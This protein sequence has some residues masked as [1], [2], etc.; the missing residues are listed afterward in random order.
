MRSSGSRARLSV[1]LCTKLCSDR[2]DSDEDAGMSFSKVLTDSTCS[3]SET[4]DRRGSNS[5]VISLTALLSPTGST[6]LDSDDEVVRMLLRSSSYAGS[7][8]HSDISEEREL[9]PSHDGMPWRVNVFAPSPFKAMVSQG[10]GAPPGLP[11]PS[12]L[13]PLTNLT[14]GVAPSERLSEA[15]V[16]Q[17]GMAPPGLSSDRR[18][19]SIGSAEH[20]TGNCKP[21][22]FFWKPGGCLNGQLCCHCHL[23]PGGA[24]KQRKKQSFTEQRKEASS[25]LGVPLSR[26]QRKQQIQQHL[27]EQQLQLQ[28]PPPQEQSVTLATEEAGS[29]DEDTLTTSHSSRSSLSEVSKGSSLHGTG[30]CKP[31]AWFWRP[32]G[33]RKGLSCGHCHTC[34][35]GELMRRRKIRDEMLRKARTQRQVGSSQRR[36]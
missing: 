1:P 32:E 35:D 3:G 27:Q 4:S 30:E 22:A 11:P 19:A 8:S 13:S 2:D 24:V 29:S 20:S 17:A 9:P 25:R 16:S 14:T 18:L 7:E 12:V 10:I 34:P 6:R 21:C 28:V 5:C 36:P 33:C 23:C 26:R 31:C 15:N